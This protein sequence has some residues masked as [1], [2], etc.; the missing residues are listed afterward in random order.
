MAI[1]TWV[2]GETITA[3][4]LNTYAGNSGLVFVKSQNITSAAATQDITS[5]FNST[6]SNYRVVIENLTTSSIIG[7]QIQFL[8][9][10]T[11][12]ATGYYWSGIEITT[13]GTVT[14]SGNA[15]VTS[16]TLQLIGFTT[17]AGG[18][19]EV[20]TPN[21]AIRT[22]Y[23]CNGVDMRTTGTS[24]YRSATGFQ[25]SNTQFDGFRILTG[26]ATTI[27]TGTVTVYGYRQS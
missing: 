8:V 15:N 27:N 26:S 24:P 20:W 12:T 10:S 3:A 21:K 9:G 23:T 14:G 17:P 1:K 18:T 2:S 16:G 25:D 4:D 6:Y 22:S 13:G 7:L 11:P 19:I 5:C